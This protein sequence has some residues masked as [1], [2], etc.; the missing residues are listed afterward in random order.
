MEGPINALFD[1]AAM[2]EGAKLRYQITTMVPGDEIRVGR[3]VTARA[4]STDH[5]LPGQ[6]YILVSEK[7]KL[8]PEYVGLEGTVIAALRKGGTVVSNTEEVIEVAYCG[9]TRITGIQGNLD[10][11]RAKLVVAEATFLG[12]TTLEFAH[13]RGHSHLTE[14]VDLAAT[15]EGHFLLIHFSARYS[16][17][18]IRKAVQ[19]ACSAK[20]TPFIEETS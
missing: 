1:A 4:F 15:C 5:T 10:V 3:G 20:F 14:V 18:E 6:G 2:A 9:D 12:D 11:K 13:E 7:S 16:N 19:A 8:K 17:K